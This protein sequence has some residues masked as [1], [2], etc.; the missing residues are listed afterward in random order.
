MLKEKQKADKK[1]NGIEALRL[2]EMSVAN[3]GGSALASIDEPNG[4][5]DLMDE[6]AALKAIED[7]LC[8]DTSP[9][10]SSDGRVDDQSAVI[11]DEEADKM[12]LKDG[13]R[14]KKILASDRAKKGVS[15]DVKILGVPLWGNDTNAMD[16]SD[17]MTEPE[18][19]ESIQD[20]RILRL[21]E[22]AWLMSG[23][24]RPL[25]VRFPTLRPLLQMLLVLPC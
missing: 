5:S 12:G 14:M 23:K 15:K 24:S 8:D 13:D 4:N 17:D 19:P 18:F 2:A 22:N 25:L 10:R 20:H 16:H 7:G 3:K 11:G 1:G 9:G 6:T 21:L